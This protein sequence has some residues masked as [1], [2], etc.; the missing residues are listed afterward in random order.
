MHNL[1]QFSSTTSERGLDYY[2]QK[3]NDLKLIILGN[4]EISR[5]STDGKVLSRLP[6]MQTLTFVLQSFKKSAVKHL[7]EKPM[8]LNFVEKPMF[9][10]IISSKVV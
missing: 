4:K 9:L 10:N 7:I 2:H 6:K 8:L 5:E 3:L 1:A